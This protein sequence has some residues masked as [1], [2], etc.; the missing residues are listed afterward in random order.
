MDKATI[1]DNRKFVHSTQVKFYSQLIFLE[2]IL[3]YKYVFLLEKIAN[4]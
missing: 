3:G 1:E 2:Q 4:F